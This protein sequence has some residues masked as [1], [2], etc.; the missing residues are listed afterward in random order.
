MLGVAILLALTPF[1]SGLLGAA[2]L[3]VIFVGPYKR[4][5]RVMPAGLASALTLIIAVFVIALPLVWL[6]SV[7]VDRV[8]DA[9][10]SLQSGLLFDRLAG[11]RLGGIDLGAQLAEASGTIVQWV[12]A[13][14]IGFVTRRR[15]GLYTFYSLADR[16]VLKLCDLMCGRI[17]A[18]TRT[19]RRLFPQ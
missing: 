2:I 4:L 16:D 6:V 17:E 1:L 11:I 9:L 14:A 7:L 12:S 15:D 8:P 10:T 3:Y 13:R 5:A 18:E 19:R